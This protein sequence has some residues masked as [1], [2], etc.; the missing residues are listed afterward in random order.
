MN[1]SI[2]ISASCHGTASPM[3]PFSP[4][5]SSPL[6]PLVHS[7]L[8]YMSIMSS[9]AT[10]PCRVLSKNAVFDFDIDVE[11]EQICLSYILRGTLSRSSA[12]RCKLDPSPS[13]YTSL[14]C[15][16]LDVHILCFMRIMCRI[17][18]VAR[19]QSF[20]WYPL[21]RIVDQNW[22]SEGTTRNRGSESLW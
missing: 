6:R 9:D 19:K 20:Y 17:P 5:R 22:F 3:F 13:Q 8:E 7:R 11:S 4:S 14:L 18:N 1:H 15:E 10:K 16:L 2:Y 21:G 12:S